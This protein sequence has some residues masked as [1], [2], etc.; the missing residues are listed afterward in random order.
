MRT[1]DKSKV[2]SEGCGRV[3]ITPQIGMFLKKD[4]CFGDN[5]LPGDS[6]SDSSWPG[7]D[8]FLP[9]RN[10][11]PITSIA[12]NVYVTGRTVQRDDGARRVRSKVEY[13]GDGEPSEWGGAWLYLNGADGSEYWVD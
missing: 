1:L 13:V 6:F 10:G 4:G 5:L 12:V 3:R 8:F 11:G 2:V 9:V 7:C